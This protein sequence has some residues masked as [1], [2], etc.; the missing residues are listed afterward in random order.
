MT[1]FG[2]GFGTGGNWR[3]A[4]DRC[5]E[6]LK[7]RSTDASGP[8]GSGLGFVYLS[9]ALA[10]DVE[11]VL[12][13][14]RSAT[15]IADWCGTVGIGVIGTHHESFDEPALSVL[16]TDFEPGAYRLLPASG[17]GDP[18]GPTGI[19]SALADPQQPRVAIVHADPQTS[20]LAE[21]LADFSQATETF[22][23]GGI[24][25]SRGH[26]PQIAGRIGHGDLSGALMGVPLVTGLTQGCSPIGP[27]RRV[28]DA[29]GH[30]IKTIDGRPALDCFREDI[31]DVLARDLR[32]TAGY[33]FAGLTIA[34]SDQTDYLVRNILAFDKDEGRIGIAHHV[35]PGDGILFCRRDPASAIADMQRVLDRLKA[36]LGGHEPRGA[37]YISCLAR[38]ENQFG[39]PGRETGLIRETFGDLP[40]TGFFANGEISHN[41]LYA[42]TGVLTL[43]R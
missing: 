31:G 3:E 18:P 23:I 42:Y 40:L 17:P 5:I 37:I 22:L 27:I 2:H 28:T 34:G 33:I 15:G 26:H 6:A 43:F 41:R 36:R 9:D 14:L 35:Q 16:L 25:S 24:A 13:R 30:V 7:D 12:D 11:A 20:H 8:A 10:G 32:R 38:G 29:D 21:R 19:E 1:G 39:E 4:T